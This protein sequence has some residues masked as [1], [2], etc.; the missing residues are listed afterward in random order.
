MST[1]T[2][3]S[4]AA[5]PLSGLILKSYCR[6]LTTICCSTTMEGRTQQQDEVLAVTN[7]NLLAT[8][9]GCSV[10]WYDWQAKVLKLV[11]ENEKKEE[12]E[13][14]EENDE[15]DS[16]HFYYNSSND[17]NRLVSKTQTF[18]T[19]MGKT[20]LSMYLVLK[21]GAFRLVDR[22]EYGNISRGL[23]T[24][25]KIFVFDFH[26]GD[27]GSQKEDWSLIEDLKNGAIF[28]RKCG[29]DKPFVAPLVLIFAGKH[30]P[31]SSCSHCRL[32]SAK[33]LVHDVNS[34]EYWKSG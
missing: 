18:E 20:F 33:L 3:T 12:E 21:H 10:E 5:E 17:K 16:V 28:R 22:Y 11:E 2:T 32:T 26:K 4:V 15:D 23:Y 30:R 13:G 27:F 7:A 6:N 25:K 34:S 19:P 24:D 31:M 9:Y 1:T 14:R 29:Y 8:M